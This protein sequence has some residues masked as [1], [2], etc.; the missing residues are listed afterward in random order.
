MTWKV[1]TGLLA[2]IMERIIYG[3]MFCVDENTRLKE[4]MAAMQVSAAQLEEVRNEK[5]HQCCEVRPLNPQEHRKQMTEALENM[6]AVH[7]AHRKEMVELQTAS[8][9]H[10]ELRTCQCIMHKQL[11]SSCHHQLRDWN[12]EFPP[13]PVKRELEGLQRTIQEKNG[14]IRG[15]QKQLADFGRER[16]TEVVK[17]RLEVLQQVKLE[18]YSNL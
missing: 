12:T 16:H 8:N 11:L 17:L 1:G 15:L 10:S 14:E 18:F 3:I 9:Q 7:E 13:I 2:Q 6:Q 5:F 4:Q